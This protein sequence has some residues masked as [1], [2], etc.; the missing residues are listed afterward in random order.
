MQF[1][2]SHLPP[3][4]QKAVGVQSLRGQSAQILKLLTK[5]YTCNTMLLAK[6][7]TAFRASHKGGE[8]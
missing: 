5:I 4:L 3:A 7:P 1:G 6:N 2:L 8:S